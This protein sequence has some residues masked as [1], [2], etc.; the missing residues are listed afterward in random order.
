MPRKQSNTSPFKKSKEAAKPSS[1][2][3]A[4]AASI[5]EP[6]VLT[7]HEI[8]DEEEEDP[9]IKKLREQSEAAALVLQRCWAR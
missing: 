8:P 1:K 6:P 2:A 5:D 9:E 4:K 7:L 3:S